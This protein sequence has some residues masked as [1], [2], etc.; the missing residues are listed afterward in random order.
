MIIPEIAARAKSLED[1]S[2][3]HKRFSYRPYR[4]G[5]MRCQWCGCKLNVTMVD[6][7]SHEVFSSPPIFRLMMQKR[8]E[9]R[10][11]VK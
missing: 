9:R 10:E 1:C 5:N 6:I 2:A 4:G 11:D 8:S 3:K 7:V